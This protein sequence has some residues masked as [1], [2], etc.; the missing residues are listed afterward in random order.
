[1]ALD[2]WGH[3]PAEAREARRKARLWKLMS[4]KPK[5]RD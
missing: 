5:H 1:M 4:R 2:M 3:T